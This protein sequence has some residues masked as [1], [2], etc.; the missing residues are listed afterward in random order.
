MFNTD[1]WKI[2][3][4]EHYDEDKIDYDLD[5]IDSTIQFYEGKFYMVSKELSI[6][7]GKLEDFAKKMSENFPIEDLMVGHLAKLMI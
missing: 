4:K 6:F 3:F 2:Y 7:I 5:F 1:I